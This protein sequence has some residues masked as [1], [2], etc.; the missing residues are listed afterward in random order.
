MHAFLLA[1]AGLVLASAGCSGA[2][3]WDPGQRLESDAGPTFERLLQA[4]PAM[5][6]INARLIDYNAML[7]R[8]GYEAPDDCRSLP[9]YRQAVA[10]ANR[11]VGFVSA[12]A[13][14]GLFDGEQDWDRHLGLR[15]CEIGG[16]AHFFN[17]TVVVYATDVDV[18][19]VA[20]RLED[21]E[22]RPTQVTALGPHQVYDWGDGFDADQGQAVTTAGIVASTNFRQDAEEVALLPQ[23]SMWDLP[24]VAG[25]TTRLAEQE[26][27]SVELRS[28]GP[29]SRSGAQS[30]RPWSL[31]GIGGGVDEEG[32]V[33]LIVAM[34]HTTEQDAALNAERF[35]AVLSNDADRLCGDFGDRLELV[36]AS[37]DAT[38]SIGV[39][40]DN[41]DGPCAPHRL[42]PYEH[43]RIEWENLFKTERE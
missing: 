21:E 1:I 24:D 30:F 33:I 7:R 13:I 42:G 17:S 38:F 25:V 10:Q 11:A 37:Y 29:G 20:Q 43:A 28:V 41:A 16:T 35:E 27:L 12:P 15:Y 40:R 8:G 22:Q 19:V 36:A 5:T 34:A 23:G 3:E 32:Q 31:L 39:Y 2:G 26:A 4:T 9:S 18:E 14:Q 6:T